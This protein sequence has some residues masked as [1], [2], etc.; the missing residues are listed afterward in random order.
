M[1]IYTKSA[2]DKRVITLLNV[3]LRGLCAAC[4]DESNS[5]GKNSILILML[6]LK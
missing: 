2:T 3:F 6:I 4:H 1:F 5:S